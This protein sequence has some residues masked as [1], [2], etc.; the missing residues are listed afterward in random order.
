MEFFFLFSFKQ[1]FNQLNFKL[2]KEKKFPLPPGSRDL[3]LVIPNEILKK[4][5]PKQ[6][7]IPNEIFFKKWP[8][9]SLFKIY[10]LHLITLQSYVTKIYVWEVCLTGGAFVIFTLA[11]SFFLIGVGWGFLGGLPDCGT[12]SEGWTAI[13]VRG[14]VFIPPCMSSQHL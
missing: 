11:E 14:M 12:L 10:N 13:C 5:W 1:I 8:K 3:Q 4:K 6:L 2:K 7:V 9:L